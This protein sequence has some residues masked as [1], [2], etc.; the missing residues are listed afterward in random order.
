MQS[1]LTY[2]QKMQKEIPG[3]DETDFKSL[4]ASCT[5]TLTSLNTE[6]FD[7]AINILF[8]KIGIITGIEIP[9]NANVYALLKNEVGNT[10]RETKRYSVLTLK[11]FEQAFN[12]MANGDFKEVKDWG[13]S[14]NMKFFFE[15]M[16][17]YC[18]YRADIFYRFEEWRG[19][20]SRK[21]ELPAPEANINNFELTEKAYQEYLS[22]KYNIML[23]NY[24]CYD[25]LV[26]CG[27]VKPDYYFKM[28]DK[29]KS[30]LIKE[31]HM[32]IMFLEKK[33]VRLD[34]TSYSAPD[35]MPLSLG[36][37]MEAI[38]GLQNATKGEKVD[39]IA[40]QL[41]MEAYFKYSAMCGDENLFI[42]APANNSNDDITK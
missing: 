32:E 38:N 25:D 37:Y 22:G 28:Y 7:Q 27:W 24:K 1:L 39:I 16:N 23:W 33:S 36:K 10:I 13:K 17:K 6:K 8:A 35:N 31:R 9:S 30:L 34:N 14:L 2:K 42:E 15:V 3:L 41:S 5:E 40:K 21:I 29:A 12:M 20:V 18:L 26:L 4:Q 19:N 11:E